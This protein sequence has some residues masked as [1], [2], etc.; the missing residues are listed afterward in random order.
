M[1]YFIN[2]VNAYLH[3]GTYEEFLEM[4]SQ[5]YLGFRGEEYQGFKTELEIYLNSNIQSLIS[6]IKSKTM[7]ISGFPP[8]AKNLKIKEEELLYTFLIERIYFDL[9]S[10]NE[11][12][13]PKLLKLIDPKTGQPND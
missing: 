5:D 6:D 12:F 9:F 7:G 3:D 13:N 10:D 1:R 11:D 4:K 8:E 2:F